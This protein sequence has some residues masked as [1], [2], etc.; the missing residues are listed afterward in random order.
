MVIDV[1]VVVV[2]ADLVVEVAAAEVLVAPSATTVTRPVTL[3]VNVLLPKT[4]GPEMVEDVGWWWRRRWWQHGV[5]QLWGA[6]THLARVWTKNESQE[7]VAV[8]V[9]ADAGVATLS[10][11]TVERQVTSPENAHLK[12]VVVVVAEEAVVVAVAAVVVVA[13]ASATNVGRRG[14]LLV[15]VRTASRPSVVEMPLYYFSGYIGMDSCAP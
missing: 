11:T 5:L 12:E 13:L 8:A 1:E 3:H 15:T 10:A 6:R 14:T 2:V 4:P 9:V 7:M